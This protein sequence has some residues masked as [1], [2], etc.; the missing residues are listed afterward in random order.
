MGGDLSLVWEGPKI[1]FLKILEPNF[2]M[3]FLGKK[4]NFSGPKFRMTFFV[5]MQY[6]YLGGR[7]RGPFHRF[8][9]TFHSLHGKM[10]CLDTFSQI[11]ILCCQNI[12]GRLRGQS[13]NLKLC[14][15]QSPITIPPWAVVVV[16]VVVVVR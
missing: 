4:F 7:H 11:Y 12:W 5:C 8:D 1:I 3:T 14:G 13:P 10:C 15:G 16:V 2:Q 6:S 9:R